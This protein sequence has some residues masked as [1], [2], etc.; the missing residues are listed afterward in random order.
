MQ[1]PL[2]GEAEGM[3]L[4][5]RATGEGQRKKG[6]GIALF[7]SLLSVIC[8]WLCLSVPCLA[9]DVT[10]I[11][12]ES[13]EYAKETSTYTA[14][15]QVKIKKGLVTIESDEIT[16]NEETDVAVSEGSMIYEDQHLRIK[17]KK[18]ELNLE[19]K[20]GMLYDAEVFSKKDNYH[21][22]GT[23]IEKIA[24]DEYLMNEA[25]FTTCDA[26]V[27]AW[28]FKG[29]DIHI[30]V[31]D[32]LKAKSVL[33]TIKDTP[34]FYS[35][36][37]SAPLDNE[38]KTGLLIP[39]LGYIKSK[40]MHYEQPFFWAISEN[41]DATFVL[42]VYTKRGIGEGLEYR[43]LETNG[44]KGNFWIYHLRDTT[45]AKDFLDLRGLFENR[46]DENKVN[47][48]LYLKYINDRDYYQEY[49]PYI[50]SKMQGLVDPAAY[51]NHTTER[52]FESNGE[53][54]QRFGNSRVYLRAQYLIDLKSGVDESTIPQRLPEIGYSMNPRMVGPFLFSLHSSISNFWREGGVSGQRLDIYPRISHSFGNDVTITQTLG[55][56]ETA[57]SLSR[58][59]GTDK[60]PHREALDYT[61]SSS[62]RLIKNYGSFMHVVEPSLGYGYIPPL[63]SDLPLF[64]STELYSKTSK[65]MLSV[66]NRFMDSNGEFLTMRITEAYDSYKSDHHLMPLTLETA[67]HRPVMF[68]GEVSYDMNTGRF[69]SI[70]TDIGLGLPNKFLFTLG[71]RY[72]RTEDILFYGVGMGYTF[73]RKLSAEGNFWYDAKGSGLGDVVTKLKYQEQCWNV[74]LVMTKRQKDYGI[75]VLFN[76]LGLGTVKL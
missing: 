15:G 52:F 7:C 35:P 62:T 29:R 18:A 75:S 48:F 33:F 16:Y 51:L 68:R 74:T 31:G 71:E 37:L 5:Q 46:E 41:R 23:E 22:R 24:D 60:S 39:A 44:A 38:R 66:L 34:V 26:P 70:N 59:E 27:P 10:T 53:V 54:S 17:A 65:V 47:S 40:G 61:I 12:S 28:C 36:Y 21:I 2:P 8:F 57:Y 76:L 6:I 20:T 1:Q 19:S 50:V 55:L 64:D 11:Q 3:N 9:E 32:T 42:D 69:E 43:F 49:N 67:F 63:T 4:G 56:R 45:L 30:L 14:K 13:L 72:N 73:S 58:T 25:S